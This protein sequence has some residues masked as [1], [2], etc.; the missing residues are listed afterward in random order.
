MSL[1]TIVFCTTCKDRAQHVKQTLPVNLADNPE[2]KI[3]LLDYCSPD[4]LLDYIKSAHMGDIESGRLVVYS[5]KNEGPFRM[6]HAKNMAHR[7]GIL[8]GGRVLVNVDA[9][10]LTGK[11]FAAY[12]AEKFQ[13]DEI[14][15]WAKMIKEG[16]ERL[17]RGISGRIAVSAE[18]FINAGGYDEKYHTWA[19]DD[20]DFNVRLR[21]LGYQAHEINKK[22][23]SGVLHNDKL[24]F[25]YYPQAQTDM[26]SDQFDE[27]NYSDSTVVNFG[28]FGKGT[29]YRNFEEEPIVLDDIPTR[30]FGIGLHKTG[31]TSLHFAL[32]ILGYESAHWKSAHWAKA[33]WLEM[34]SVGRSLTL[35]KHYALTDLPI[36][37]LYDKLDKAY[38]GSKFILTTRDE[39]QW[40][41][42]VKNHWD[43]NHNQFRGAW[44]TDPFTHRLHKEVYGQK[45]FN[46]D[47]FLARFRKHNAAVIEHFKDRPND[48]LVMDINAGWPALCNFLGKPIPKDDYPKQYVTQK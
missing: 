46:A 17:P 45:G 4:D 8:E 20:K 40:L 16:A 24:R 34:T 15:L 36:G 39:N 1:S 14:F 29:V 3:V 22:F 41:E 47:I 25:K 26:G 10:N 28:K 11:G 21:R 37:I 2:A 27:V 12:V 31:T 19:P 13:E 5:Y 6:A 7:L 42:S 43:H 32:K 9:D 44:D 35:E 48:L 33:I 23:L 18:A 30:I 38:P